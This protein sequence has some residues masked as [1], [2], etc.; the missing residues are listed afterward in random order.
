MFLCF[1][2]F[3]R[4]G[5]PTARH[6]DIAGVCEAGLSRTDPDEM[7][8]TLLTKVAMIKLV[9]YTKESPLDLLEPPEMG[10]NSDDLLV[11]ITWLFME[12]LF[13]KLHKDTTALWDDVVV[14]PT[15]VR[16]DVTKL[17][18]RVVMLKT[19]R[20]AQKELEN[21]RRELVELQE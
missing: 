19:G 14:D 9:S 2:L 5:P 1:G 6:K 18:N 11:P 13:A 17:G 3:T 21:H 20:D 8:W 4:C 12:A 10:T 16:K 7:S 15:K